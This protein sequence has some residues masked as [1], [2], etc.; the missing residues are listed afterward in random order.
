[1]ESSWWWPVQLPMSACMVWFQPPAFLGHS[2]RSFVAITSH[3]STW[4]EYIFK[5]A[6]T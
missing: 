2:W 4:L 5:S 3:L 6:T 1:L